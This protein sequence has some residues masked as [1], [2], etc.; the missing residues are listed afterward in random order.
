MSGCGQFNKLFEFEK[1]AD[2]KLPD[3]AFSA[4]H[5]EIPELQGMKR[6]LN[7]VKG[8]LNQ[9]DLHDWHSHTKNRFLAGFVLGRLKAKIKAE[10]LT[11]AWCKFYEILSR[12]PSLIDNS[13]ERFKSLHLC[14]AP[15]AFISALNHRLASH[16]PTIDWQWQAS[17][18]NPYYE[19]NSSSAMI[20]DDQLIK[21]THS[22]WLFGADQTGDLLQYYNHVDIVNK[23]TSNGKLNLITA[24]GSIDCMSDPGEQERLV[25]FLHY[26]ETITAL[27]SLAP[28]GSF[29]LKI[30]TMFEKSTVCL[31]YLLCCVFKQT[32][33]FK[34]AT[35]KSGNSELYV[36]CLTYTELLPSA[37]I[38]DQLVLP[39]KKG[40]FNKTQAM[41]SLSDI[42]DSFLLQLT[43]SCSDFFLQL[44]TNTINDNIYYYQNPL[45]SDQRSLKLE[46]INIAH[47]Y[48]RRYQVKPIP[49]GRRLIHQSNKRDLVD[50]QRIGQVSTK[51]FP[52]MFD[53]INIYI[54]KRIDVVRNSKFASLDQVQNLRYSSTRNQTQ[55]TLY[56]LVLS[57][58]EQ[59][60][61]VINA[62]SFNLEVYFEYQR[63][64][65][66][67]LKA[68][69]A[70]GKHVLLL[71]VPLHTH[72]LAGMWWLL[73]SAFETVYFK[74]GWC[75]FYKNL[76][77]KAN[78]V[79]DA[80]SR[81]E[82]IYNTFSADSSQAFT[83]D[84][85]GLFDTSIFSIGLSFI[86][87]ILNVYNT[88]SIPKPKSVAINQSI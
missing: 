87:S 74:G 36:V 4:A 23:S 27:A 57:R 64:L 10:L 42:P 25:E 9:F 81:V 6:E 53:A 67:A 78:S 14:E 76:P 28:G 21:H 63:S 72:F 15:G 3:N 60:T 1:S 30:F 38:W 70:T 84:I 32:F 61:V 35:S 51:D 66:N 19:E 83:A 73:A 7:S 12:F 52:D 85:I 26:C 65:F 56:S 71:N 69:V 50:L 47:Y 49:K 62:S 11:Q 20:S 33:L 88:F 24:D 48:M 29:V 58:V 17:T 31:L 13:V 16:Y 75:L 40:G 37:P 43:G 68:A 5:F 44:Q 77:D 79:R 8:Q 80:F 39:Y 45:E 18:L 86:P 34:P 22:Q 2:W 46:K 55:S 54:G 82:N 59:S 41:F